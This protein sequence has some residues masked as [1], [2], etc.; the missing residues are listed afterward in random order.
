I[1]HDKL[2]VFAAAQGR[3][4]SDDL[5]SLLSANPATLRRLGV[6]S[7]SV[8]RFLALVNGE[9]VSALEGDVG[10]DRSTNAGSALVRMDYIINDSH[11][12]MLRGDWRLNSQNP[13][14][15]SA[16]ALPMGGGT[17]SD[18]GGGIMAALTS[19]FGSTVINEARAYGA[20]DDRTSSPFLALPVARVQISSN[21]ADSALGITTLGFGGSPSLPQTAH[22]KSL[23]VSDELSWLPGDASHRIK[24]GG[25]LN[26][27]R[28]DQDVT[29]NRE[30]VF[31]FNS[32]QDLAND[33]P[34]SFS[35]TLA[36]VQ[37]S[38]SA[39][40]PALYLGDTWRTS[41]ALQL[42]YGVRL[43]SSIYGGAPAGNAVVDSAFGLR[44][45]DFP[46]EVHV[47]PRVGF[48]WTIGEGG[49]GAPTT[50]VRG[51][52][53]EFR[54]L[55]PSALFSA[56]EGAT[57]IAGTES[58]LVCIGSAVPTPDWSAYASDPSTIPPTCA[59]ATPLPSSTALP[60]VT[61]FDPHFESPRAWRASL[62]V[63]RR[64]LDRFGVSLDASYARGVSLYGFQDVNLVS[65]PSFGLSSEND[66]PVYVPATSIV[67]GTGAVDFSESRAVP[68]L[69]H[70]IEI[71]SNLQSD[72]RQLSLGVNGVTVSG[73]TFQASY[74]YMRSRDQS[75]FSCCSATQG[76]AAVTTTGDP[77]A[78]GWATSDFERRH[79]FLVT[80]SYALSQ[81]VELT[82]VTRLMSGT[83]YT[84]MVSGDINGDG[85]SNDRAF[86]FAASA[87]D[88]AVANGMSRLLAS[89][90]PSVR[91][92]LLSQT[93]TIANRNSC[94]GSWQPSAD[95]Q[96]NFRPAWWGLDRRMTLMVSTVNL[97]AG[98]DQ[99]V[100]GSNDLHGW[101][102]YTRP[103]PTLLYVR[104]F[105]P[106]SQS[107]TY[108]VNQRFGSTR[109]TANA[110]RVPFQL[111]VQARYV[112]GPDQ[113]AER[114]RGLFGGGGGRGGGSR[115]GGSI[116][117]AGAGG[118]GAAANSEDLA[119][120]LQRMLP[121]PAAQ[122][123][124]L[125]DSL[126]LTDS[127]VVRLTALRD[128]AASAYAMAADS[129]RAAITKAGPNADPT[130]LFA[131]MR[132]QLT[133]GR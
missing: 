81:S 75:S 61:V 100:H 133:K 6:A 56:A 57:G 37:R 23:E 95:L 48:T 31:T 110:F 60:G 113:N 102:G 121:N 122:L 14:R 20:I 120:R 39:V 10:T 114:L 86:I 45:S 33:Q 123:L 129:I 89:A 36:P 38:G 9:G 98:I 132:P 87:R 130:R 41:G 65:R 27:S 101:G 90:S 80:A 82:T 22:T 59:S 71:G 111:A 13:T 7:D 12:L 103:D 115:G 97:L 28:F 70:V 40:N 32:L 77:N 91:S 128:S 124:E 99:L 35:R 25:L 58:Q 84:P 63:Q 19:H 5:A 69:G 3:W 93:G 67:P 105:D 11:T 16:Y 72:N 83:P 53:G 46:S 18:R 15:V 26:A 4:R 50:I 30:G 107:F 104:G 127:Q 78:V 54:S 34:S 1:V 118:E 106:V 43:E 126:A 21:V 8:A 79:Q 116:G 117:G 108:A 49:L 2:F 73:F 94:S 52:A 44:T 66:R 85:A 24:L 96:M 64:I 68:S 17:M 112:I 62:G 119:D 51:G 125:R 92:C 109:G 88:T 47:S 55:T 76:F 74:T 42:T 131:A 29:N